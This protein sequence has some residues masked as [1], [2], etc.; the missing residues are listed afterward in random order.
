M[1]KQQP[2]THAVQ[3]MTHM[4]HVAEKEAARQ[5]SYVIALFALVATLLI[6]RWL[7][8]R[9]IHWLPHSGIGVLVGAFCAGTLR[10]ESGFSASHI[11][12]DVLR[13][14]RFSSDVFMSFLLPPIIFDAGFNIDAPAAMRNLGPTT[15][16]AFVGTTFSTFAVGLLCYGA[17]QLGVCYPLGL[18]AS[19]T[20][21]SLI[22]ATDPVSVLSVFKALGVDDDV[23]AIVFGESVLNDAVA[24]VLTRTMLAF[25]SGPTAAT[26]E[27]GMSERV[28]RACIV[29]VIE[30]ASSLLIGIAFGSALALLLRRLDVRSGGRGGRSGERGGHGDSASASIGEHGGGASASGANAREDTDTISDDLVLTVALTFAFPWAS[31]YTAEALEC[32]GIV[33]LL[34]CGVVMAQ[35]A[36]PL[37]CP[38]AVRVASAAFKSAGFVAETGVFIYLGEAVFSLPILHNTTWRLTLV[39]MLACAL[40]RLHIPIGVWLTNAYRAAAQPEQGAPLQR[41]RAIAETEPHSHL[42]PGVS[43]VLWWS[44]LRGGVAFALATASFTN[45]EFAQHCGGLAK[46]SAASGQ[47]SYG[48][49]RHC[50]EGTHSAHA[51]TDGLA[52]LQVTLIVAAFSIFVLGGSIKRVAE[53]CGVIKAQRAAGAAEVPSLGRGASRSA[54]LVHAADGGSKW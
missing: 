46:E 41:A 44:G 19:L 45:K 39:A 37:M 13:D 2:A 54:L 53:S 1:T 4:E 33:T 16:F 49:G 10:W 34:F 3:P 29:F 15:F 24:I 28:A 51:M 35:Y 36:R 30:F 32:S 8:K 22:S 12:N 7:E 47:H 5:L 21:G 11:D 18:L 25:N 26:S 6:G 31:Y 52:I 9:H 23:F 40:G 27:L 43:V 14:E 48:W 20:F 42:S 50:S 17:G 38:A